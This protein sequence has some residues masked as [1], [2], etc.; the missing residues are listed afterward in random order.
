MSR[1]NRI[2][3]AH[4][5]TDDP[6]GMP[7]SPT[8]KAVENTTASDAKRPQFTLLCVDD[9]PDI[10]L[11]LQ[12]IFRNYECEILTAKDGA[13]AYILA[14]SHPVDLILCDLRMPELDGETLLASL[15]IRQDTRETPI[16]ILSAMATQERAH[17]LIDLGA[18]VVLRKPT[19]IRELVEEV[20]KLVPL[21]EVDWRETDLRAEGQNA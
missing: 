15:R 5:F 2:H 1:F 16:I 12:I 21:K 10:L 13:E 20:R 4:T 8:E 9:D 11:G 14:T 6:G 7:E 3:D 17:G 18:S 19:T